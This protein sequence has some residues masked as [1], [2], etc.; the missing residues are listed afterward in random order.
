MKFYSLNLRILVW[1]KPY[2]LTRTQIPHIR[3]DIPSEPSQVHCS[4]QSKIL[5]GIPQGSIPGHLAFILYINN[6]PQLTSIMFIIK[7][8]YANNIN[9]L[10]HHNKVTNVL[11]IAT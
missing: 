1:I 2:L 7:V 3:Y 10:H 4:S 5:H 8:P 9:K 11:N 6:L